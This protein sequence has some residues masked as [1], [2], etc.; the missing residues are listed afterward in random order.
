MSQ[1]QTGDRVINLAGKTGIIAEVSKYALYPYRVVLD[2]RSQGIYAASELKE[3]STKEASMDT[4]KLKE[5]LA[6]W[7]D[8][9]VIA[10]ALVDIMAEETEPGEMTFENAKTFYYKFLETQL[11]DGL[12][13]VITSSAPWSL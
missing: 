3:A 9:G 11:H 8:P 2:D 5:Q 1:F 7:I 6:D 12:K 13:T 10:D 4:E